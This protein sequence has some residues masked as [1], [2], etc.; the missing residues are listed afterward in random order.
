MNVI[1]NAIIIDYQTRHN[2]G[3]TSSAPW[4]VGVLPVGCGWVRAA[5][6]GQVQGG[7]GCGLLLATRLH[8]TQTT[9]QHCWKGQCVPL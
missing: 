2:T 1:L 7:S 5:A 6:S 3:E 8:Q 4:G 9:A